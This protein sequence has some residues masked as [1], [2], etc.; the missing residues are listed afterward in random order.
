MQAN[1]HSLFRILSLCLTNC[2]ELCASSRWKE[3]ISIALLWT[4]MVD[5][6]SP[7]TLHLHAFLFIRTYGKTNTT[8][9]KVIMLLYYIEKQALI[10]IVVAFPTSRLGIFL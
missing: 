8:E 6:P 2:L 7:L 5:V 9:F 3:S 10:R 1:L 4:E